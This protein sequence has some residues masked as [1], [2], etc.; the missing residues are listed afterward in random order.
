MHIGWNEIRVRAARFADEWKDARY[1]KGDTQSFYNEFFEVFGVR[2]RRVASYEEPVRLLG[3]RRGFIDLFW[4]GTLLVEQKSAGRDLAPAKTQALDYFPGLKDSELPRYILLSDF[5]TFE[6]YDLDEGAPPLKFKLKEFPRHV[7]TFGFMLGIQTRQ[8]RDHDPASIDAANLMG[9][10]HDAL[11]ATGYRGHALERLLVRLLFCLFAEHTGIFEPGD[12]AALIQDRTREDGSDLGLWL[13]HL[14]EVLN[15]PREQRQSTLDPDLARFDYINGRL[16]EEHLPAAIFDTNMRNLLLE[17]CDFRWSEISAAIFGSLFQFVMNPV[18]RRKQG[19]HYTSERDILKV[20]EPLFL[21]ELRAELARCK[22]LQRGREAALHRLQDKIAGLRLFDPACGCGNFLVIAYRELRLLELEIL[23]SLFPDRR[24][25]WLDVASLS[26]VNVDQFFG[27]E[28]DEFATL[29]AEVALWL[30]DHIAN[31]QLSEEFGESYVRIPLKTSPSIRCGDALEMDWTEVL[32]PSDCS[33]VFGNPPFGGAK[34]QST[35]QR[36]QVRR[37]ANLGRSGGTLD[38]VTAWFFKAGEFVQRGGNALIGFVATN[39]ITQGEQ[40]AQLWPSLFGRYQLEISFAHRTFA[41][42]SEA[43]GAAHVHVVIIGLAP[44]SRQPNFKRLFSYSDPYANPHETRHPALSAYLLDASGLADPHVV[45]TERNR[46]LADVPAIESGTQP[47]DNSHLI[48]N[49]DERAVFL[50]QE[51]KAR[52]FMRPFWGTTEFLSGAG[53]WILALQN[54]T[55]AQLRA[56]PRVRNRLALVKKFRK[57]SKRAQTLRIADFPTRFNV[58]S[59]PT[60]DYLAIPEV[61]SENREYIPIGW[62]S[63][64][65]IPSNLLRIIEGADLWHFGIITSRMHMAWARLIGGRLESRLRYSSGINYNCFVWPE[66]NATQRSRISNLA[67]RVLDARTQAGSVSYED[68]Y[69]PIAMTPNLRRAHRNLDVAVD[70]L[71]RQSGFQSDADR[72]TF[73]LALY[74]R[75]VAPLQVAARPARRRGREQ[76]PQ[77]EAP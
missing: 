66:A 48:F 64:P 10:L 35:F 63:P 54:A 7:N 22:A 14:F 8:F 47:I 67:Q 68:M 26:H 34:Y 20:I 51:P 5:Q 23:K 19:A 24:Q 41:W 55:P 32:S 17:A 12:F 53:R 65:T 28:L 37:I 33:F 25:G 31:N 27:I 15:T 6:L 29:I 72:V 61:S 30:T 43:R 9:K 2:R 11:E 39:S 3:A 46:P 58:E 50:R 70:R 75:A 77:A 40:V 42:E 73:L 49:A 4:K 59:I 18:E 21:D 13:N 36:A 62:L 74:E 57:A 45:V 56:M 52:R 16:F 60:A 1:E 69:D 71:Y 76:A 38:F 44:R